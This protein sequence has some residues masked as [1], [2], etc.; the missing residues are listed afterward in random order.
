MRS[1]SDNEIP[2]NK[3]QALK[4]T[5]PPIESQRS[6]RTSDSTSR[7]SISDHLNPTNS[8]MK[9]LKADN[10][11]EINKENISDKFAI[12]LKRKAIINQSIM[13]DKSIKINTKLRLNRNNSYDVKSRQKLIDRSASSIDR[14]N[15]NSVSLYDKAMANMRLSQNFEN[16]KNSN[17][18]K[19]NEH[20]Q[21][22][23]S[24]NA[25]QIESENAEQD[26]IYNEKLATG[27]FKMLLQL[28]I[29]F[30]G[31]SPHQARTFLNEIYAR[32]EDHKQNIG[33]YWMVKLDDAKRAKVS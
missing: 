1:D 17:E 21:Q 3:S 26:E 7:S 18:S 9:R 4:L 8:N 20:I 32:F 15:N 23:S 5:P 11:S 6:S 13:I 29:K 16:V 2:V 30:P 28:E 33:N 24:L 31:K 12:N 22:M 27:V 19:V 10:N 14:N 25:K